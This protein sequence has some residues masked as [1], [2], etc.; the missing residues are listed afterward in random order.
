MNDPDELR[1][2]LQAFVDGELPLGDELAFEARLRAE[3]ALRT[4]V[5]Q[6]RALKQVV[7]EQGERHAAPAALRER[8]ASGIAPPSRDTSTST[9]SAPARSTPAPAWA[10]WFAS[11]PWL[12]AAAAASLGVAVFTTVLVPALRLDARIEDELVASHVRAT[13]GQRTVDVASSDHHTV[14]PWLS[15]RLDFSPPVQELEGTPGAALEGGR[16]DYIGGRP[17]AALAYRYAGHQVDEYVWPAPG[18]DG[19]RRASLRGFQ[20][21]HWT[22]GGMAHWLVSD[23]NAS[24]LDALAARLR[25]RQ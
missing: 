5:Q 12:G 25:A 1:W 15:S 18:S 19:L 21:A 13:L 22:D 7:R 16:V 20:L 14:K 6:L 9:P 23:L 17:V 4:Q 11:R 8:I 10:R 3:P 2:R 24:E